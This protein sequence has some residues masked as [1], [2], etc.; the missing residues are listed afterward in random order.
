[1]KLGFVQRD[2]ED[3]SQNL[4]VQWNISFESSLNADYNGA[5]HSFIRPS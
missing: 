2:F 3:S 4:N 5:N 1:M